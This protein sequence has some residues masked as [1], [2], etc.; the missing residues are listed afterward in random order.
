M[1]LMYAIQDPTTVMG[2]GT[3]GMVQMKITVSIICPLGIIESLPSYYV[4]FRCIHGV[5]PELMYV[6]VTQ[7]QLCH[8]REGCT[9][10]DLINAPLKNNYRSWVAHN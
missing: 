9:V 5:A 6:Y 10:S 4:V 7:Y 1:N 2:S 3:V 8:G